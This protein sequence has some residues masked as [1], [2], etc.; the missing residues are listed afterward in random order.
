MITKTINEES[1]PFEVKK[2]FKKYSDPKWELEVTSEKLFQTIIVIPSI[3]EYENIKV[4][5]KSLAVNDNYFFDQTLIVF[6][7]NNLPSAEQNIKD[8]NSKSIQLI[9]S[10]IN[11]EENEDTL[12]I[13]SSGLNFGLVDMS[14]PGKEMPE[15]E[16]GVGVA[17]KTGMDL[18]LTC[19]DYNSNVKKVL[20]CL[21]GDCTVSKNY[22]TEIN[23]EFNKRNLSAAYVNFHH[24]HVGSEEEQMA[25]ICYEIFLRNYV[26]G[27]QYA[28]SPYGLHTI[29]STMACDYESYI[30]IQGMNKR[31]AAEDFYFMEK[32]AK[33]VKV[34][35]I[36]SATVFPSG[37]GS[38]RVPFGT[39]QR[40]NRYLSHEQNEYVLYNPEGFM[41][42]KEWLSIF[43]K[44][45][46]KPSDEYLNLAGQ[47]HPSVKA[48]LLDQSF[49]KAWD[50]ILKNS[51]KAEQIQKQ[52]SLWFDGFRTLKFIHFLRD[53]G[54][55]LVSM[56]EALDKMFELYGVEEKIER[57][58]EIPSKEIQLK[59]LS[60]LREIA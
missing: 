43:L 39:G 31:K 36:R 7:I 54:F 23:Q 19:F 58:E 59:Y 15:K 11:N 16:G 17:R 32:L 60:V 49:P 52:K 41:L 18:A 45:K 35:T 38:W 46:N 44:K 33:N 29:G 22:I 13:I 47:I 53:N 25:I 20:V 9:R 37:R 40:V 8:D 1:L 10:L 28:K 48:F 50:K 55:P 12:E 3:S 5:L 51:G 34:K 42:L 2:Y 30:K 21:D 6:A 14:T 27:L 56:F 24:G 4:L 26:L 57:T